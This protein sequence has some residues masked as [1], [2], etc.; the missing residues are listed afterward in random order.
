MIGAN[1]KYKAMRKYRLRTGNKQKGLQYKMQQEQK[2]ANSQQEFEPIRTN[3][4]G[5]LGAVRPP[6]TTPLT[7]QFLYQNY[8]LQAYYQ[9]YCTLQNTLQYYDTLIC[10]KCFHIDRLNIPGNL[11]LPLD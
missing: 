5:I 11:S 10:T 3:T 1:Q 9:T 6:N 4:S 2:S 8:H 7:S